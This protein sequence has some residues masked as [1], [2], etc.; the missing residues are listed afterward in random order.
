MRGQDE[1]A[2][3]PKRYANSPAAHFRFI[4]KHLKGRFSNVKGY[5]FERVK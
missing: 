3:H 4:V 2:T 1:F 5:T